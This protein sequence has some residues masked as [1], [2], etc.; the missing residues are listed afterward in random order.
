MKK[1]VLSGH[2]F[3][4][5]PFQI[6]EDQFDVTYP[7][8]GHFKKDQILDIIEEYEVFIPNF[9][10]YT[11]KEIIDKAKNLKL[12]ANFG[13]GYNNIDAEYAAQKGIAVTNTPNSVLEPTA[14]LCFGLIHA[15][16]RRIGF[17]NN[18]LRTPEG[19]SWGL[20]DNPGIAIFGKTLGIYG[21]GRI[22]QAVARRAVAAGMDIIYHNRKPVA[23]GIEEQYNARYVSFEELLSQSDFISVNAPATP[24]T[25]H[26]IDEKAIS[27]MKPDAILINTSRGSTVDEAA[28]IKALKNNRI[29]GAGLDVFENEPRINP[30][31][32]VL[33]NVVLT[34]HTGTQ[35]IEGRYDMQREVAENIINFYNGGVIS[36]VN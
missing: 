19:L 25:Y 24:E 11:D 16:A 20:Y 35:T 32:L 4:R 22:G 1:K 27:K 18:K 34:P 9:S 23:K 36:K 30:E 31:F 7:S 28:L 15:V 29:F 2:N 14:E 8:T 21:F 10:F 26:I 5:E 6:L 12:I 17:Y 33:D 3:H 13:V